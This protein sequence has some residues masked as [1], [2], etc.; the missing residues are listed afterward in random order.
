M[1]CDV[2]IRRILASRD[3]IRQH[4][5]TLISL[6]CGALILFPDVEMTDPGYGATKELRSLSNRLSL[7]HNSLRRAFRVQQPTV[8]ASSS[9]FSWPARSARTSMKYSATA[10]CC[11]ATEALAQSFSYAVLRCVQ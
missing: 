7:R 8:S 9:S 4:L 1:L 5:A 10:I 6:E 2:K 11:D 3:R